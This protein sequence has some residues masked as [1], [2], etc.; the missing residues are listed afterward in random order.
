VKN[1]SGIH[2]KDLQADFVRG[3]IGKNG[4]K[5]TYPEKQ[6]K[7]KLSTAT[8][9]HGNKKMVERVKEG[10]RWMVL[11]EHECTGAIRGP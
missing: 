2:K 8:G 4:E 5:E 1:C 11:L 6:S 3:N 9:T 10:T 7:A